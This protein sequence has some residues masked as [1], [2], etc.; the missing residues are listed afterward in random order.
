MAAWP[1]E[2]V[3]TINPHYLLPL[4]PLI[5]VGPKASKLAHSYAIRETTRNAHIWEIDKQQQQV[6]EEEEEEAAAA[7]HIAHILWDLLA[8]LIMEKS[9]V[10]DHE[11]VQI[12]I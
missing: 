1:T 5:V 11:R 9:F 8:G 3:L 10:I 7:A 12:A 2:W 6:D 4:L